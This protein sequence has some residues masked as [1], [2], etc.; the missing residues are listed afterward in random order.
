MA[1]T[2][3]RWGFLVLIAALAV[4]LFLFSAA[5]LLWLLA[6]LLGM[7]AVLWLLLRADAR[8]LRLEARAVPGGQV[9]RPLK[10]TITASRRGGLLAADCLRVEL[11]IQHIMFGTVRHQELLLPLRQWEE[12]FETELPAELC[13]ETVFCCKAA[14]VRDQMGLFAA[15]CK[16]FAECRTVCYPMPFELEAAL[17][18]DTVGAASTEG[19]MQNRKGGDPSETFDVREYAPGDDIRA[20]HWKLSCK[21][22]TLVLREASDPSHY[23]VALLPD[24]GLAQAGTPASDR[25]LNSA[26][27][28]TVSLGE[29]L[30]RQGVSFCLVLPTRQGLYVNEV[31]SLRELH[32][33]LP[34]WLG[35]ELPA[36][37][38]IGLQCFR[39]EHM[40]QYFT[41]LLIVSAGRYA[42][43]ATVLSS[44]IGV[45]VISAAEDVTAP[46][47]TALG[48]GCEAVLLPAEQRPG[49]SYRIVC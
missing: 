14:E 46:M 45:T 36:E 38:G 28:I 16:P 24:I 2:K 21:T 9:G 42:Q 11:E 18:R 15:R 35:L 23:D 5:Y 43:D 48:G 29:Q 8:Q 6:V 7:A 47:R 40:E 32:R 27:G 31:R 10:L 3:R 13:G 20:I 12:T 1:G 33:V 26:T 44:R 25:E 41:R 49:E 34:Q 39:T 19:L 4:L 17:S 22:D 30:L 37:G